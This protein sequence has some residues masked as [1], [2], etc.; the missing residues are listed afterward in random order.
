[1]A[2]TQTY[3]DAHNRKGK[4]ERYRPAHEGSLHALQ[5]PLAS[6]CIS[7]PAQEANIPAGACYQ[8]NLSNSHIISVA[9]GDQTRKNLGDNI[10]LNPHQMFI[11]FHSLN[12]IINSLHSF[13]INI[14][15]LSNNHRN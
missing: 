2:Q 12:Q 3:P 13:F 11:C 15:L 14:F 1:M 8:Q 7:H 10:K 6:G 9:N 5:Q 4:R